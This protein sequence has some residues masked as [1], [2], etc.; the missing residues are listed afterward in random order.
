MR[1]VFL[2]LLAGSAC[3]I[4]FAQELV[5][6]DVL[7]TGDRALAIH[8]PILILGQKLTN[9]SISDDGRYVVIVRETPSNR[10][11]L[12]GQ[13]VS[14]PSRTDLVVWDSRTGSI[15]ELRLPDDLQSRFVGLSWM[16]GTNSCLVELAFKWPEGTR[17][18]GK[19][20][21][22]VH[23]KRIMVL[24]PVNGQLKTVY[25][26]EPFLTYQVTSSVSPTEAK[27]V[28]VVEAVKEVVVET[29]EGPVTYHENDISL[30]ILG[31]NGAIERNVKLP[32][33]SA[34][35]GMSGW[36][37]DG[38]TF[39][40]EIKVGSED[41]RRSVPRVLLLDVMTGDLTDVAGP[42]NSYQHRRETKEIVVEQKTVL[43]EGNGT[44][45]HQWWLKAPAD[46][47]ST[48]RL[49]VEHADFA[50]LSPK[51]DYVLYSF[52]GSLFVRR[53]QE[54]T[55]QA[56]EQFL[57]SE[58]QK[59]AMSKA[60]QVMLGLLM[61]AVDYDDEI[62]TNLSFPLDI[63]PYLRNSKVADGFV[64]TFAGG[65]LQKY[66]SAPTEIVGYVDTKYGRATA[67]LDGHVEWESK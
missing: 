32:E 43:I 65:D 16:K 1:R 26:S 20:V 33:G 61:Y 37:V 25:E 29:D 7:V 13:S 57:A 30:K 44:P 58:A 9:I 48:P 27:A 28:I 8:D 54:L 63:E 2:L 38:R 14:P 51:D 18:P 64:Y 49:V 5:L 17:E 56:Y 24:N 53:I 22:L 12:L 46:A 55:A 52:K 21:P 19:H 66:S 60:K 23:Q 31:A 4:S 59:N 35:P 10:P 34:N 42:V 47:E 67:Y 36:S 3:A 41:G 45:A 62:R 15:K 11:R 50:I 6:P 39:Q 40:L